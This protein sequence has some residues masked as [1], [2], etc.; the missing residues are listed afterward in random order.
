MSLLDPFIKTDSEE[1][2]RN[3]KKCWECTKCPT[4]SQGV[5]ALWPGSLLPHLIAC[6][7]LI[8]ELTLVLTLKST[9]YMPFKFM[10]SGLSFKVILY[11]ITLHI[12]GYRC[13]L[14][15]NLPLNIIIITAKLSQPPQN[16]VL[17]IAKELIEISW[18]AIKV[19]TTTVSSFSLCK[20]SVSCG[21]EAY[22]EM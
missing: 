11:R 18:P 3:S 10:V 21:Q 8:D 22:K 13:P 2:Q 4:C 7:N 19:L 15:P 12:Y 14:W 20:P 1:H 9:F 5:M 6:Y 17:Q 16:C